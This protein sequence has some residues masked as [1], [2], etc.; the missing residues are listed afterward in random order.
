[1][2]KHSAFTLVEVLIAVMMSA[3][4]ALAM[5]AIY[6]TASRHMFQDYRSN[7]VKGNLGVAMR[8]INNAVTQ[9]NRI[10]APA[11]GTSGFT[12]AVVANM[13]QLSNCAP[14]MAGQPVLV[15]YFCINAA[16]GITSL[17]YYY[18][19]VNPPAA[20]ACPTTALAVGACNVTYPPTCAGPTPNWT[21][22]KLADNMDTSASMFSRVAGDYVNDNMSVGVNLRSIWTPTLG[23]ATTQRKVDFNLKS[24]YSVSRAK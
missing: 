16:A 23:L 7:I 6:S 17:N 20:C 2:R 21:Y 18:R 24:I 22:I 19:T 8:A 9:S 11:P 1:M 15:H 4:I 5:A 3:Y 13:D 12:L 10:D 14:I